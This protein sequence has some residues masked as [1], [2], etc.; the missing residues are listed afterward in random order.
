[1]LELL[2]QAKR[3]LLAAENVGQDGHV[4][5]CAERLQAHHMLDVMLDVGDDTGRRVDI[6]RKLGRGDASDFKH[7]EQ[8]ARDVERDLV[9]LLALDIAIAVVIRHQARTLSHVMNGVRQLAR[10]SGNI[11]RRTSAEQPGVPSMH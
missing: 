2:E 7:L 5:R 3:V 9:D 4:Q 6:R 10:H 11:S 1:M 8:T